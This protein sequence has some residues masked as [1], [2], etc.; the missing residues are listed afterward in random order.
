LAAGRH[1]L[2]IFAKFFLHAREHP[3]HHVHRAVVQTRLHMRNG[4]CPDHFSRVLD[5]HARQPR[6][7][8]KQRL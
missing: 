8:R 6:R 4:I 3:I 7:P 1:N 2:G 5:L